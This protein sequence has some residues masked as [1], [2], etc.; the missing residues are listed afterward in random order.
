MNGHKI[1]INKS[2]VP[3]GTGGRGEGGRCLENK[4]QIRCGLK[5][6]NF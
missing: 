4:A 6:P 3:V 2:T 1:I 5:P